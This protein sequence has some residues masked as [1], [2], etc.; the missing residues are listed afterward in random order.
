[1]KKQIS[2]CI[3]LS[4]VLILL[5]LTFIRFYNSKKEYS[6]LNT[7]QVTEDTMGTEGTEEFVEIS[8]EYTRYVYYIIEEDGRL[9]VY[10]TNSDELYMESGIFAQDLPNEIREKLNE[11]IFFKSESDLYDFLESYSS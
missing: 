7:T 11:G 2:I 5:S 1:M 6:D 3:F 4:I 8:Q 9:V 10:E